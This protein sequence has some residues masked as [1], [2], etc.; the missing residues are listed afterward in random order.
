M[1]FGVRRLVRW[2]TASW[3]SDPTIAAPADWAGRVQCTRSRPLPPRP[4]AAN[5]TCHK[6]S[7]YASVRSLRIIHHTRTHFFFWGGGG[8]RDSRG[9]SMGAEMPAR[10]RH[11]PP[12]NLRSLNMYIYI[13]RLWWWDI[14]DEEIYYVQRSGRN[15]SPP[16]RSLVLFFFPLSV[17][18]RYFNYTRGPSLSLS[19]SQ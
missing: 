13:V 11:F 16:P 19:L 14:P 5:R 12:L 17:S 6:S 3:R 2:G 10:H 1:A 4:H 7:M 8:G 18:A 15:Y 9:R